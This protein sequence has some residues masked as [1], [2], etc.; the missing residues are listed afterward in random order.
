MFIVFIKKIHY[1]N[2]SVA[3]GKGK[4]STTNNSNG[5]NI[6]ILYYNKGNYEIIDS[7]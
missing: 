7:Y 1:Y 3:K 2:Q 6:T 4:C 5:N